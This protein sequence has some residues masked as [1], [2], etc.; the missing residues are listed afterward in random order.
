VNGGTTYRSAVIL[1]SGI[2]V[3]ATIHVPD[4][5]EYDEQHELTAATERGVD[6]IINGGE[7]RR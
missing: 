6:T 5:A 4:D 2:T 1:P 3:E 7:L